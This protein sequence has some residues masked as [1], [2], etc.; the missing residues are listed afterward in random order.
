[1][2]TIRKSERPIPGGESQRDRVQAESRKAVRAGHCGHCGGVN[3]IRDND[4]MISCLNCG[5]EA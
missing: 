2:R 5:W 3:L 4:G 1:M